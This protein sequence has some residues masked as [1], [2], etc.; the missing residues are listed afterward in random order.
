MLL[1]TFTKA[2][3][4]YLAL[5]PESAHRLR[6]LNHRIITVELLPFHYLFQLACTEQSVHLHPGDALNAETK[7][8][9]TPLQFLG[10][11]FD[12]ENRK[13]FFAED[14]HIEGNALIGQEIINLFDELTIDWE[15][16]LSQITGDAAAYYLGQ[17][18][19]RFSQW[20]KQTETAF[21]THINDYLHEEAEWFPTKEALQDLFADIDNLRMDTDRLQVKMQ[22]LIHLTQQFLEEN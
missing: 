15:E 16:H 4:A 5:D 20:F 1:R 9:G 21:S 17:A 14:I 13:R 18:T 11:F 22:H 10:M 12:A 19:K 6:L 3:N 2:L 7:I 8:T